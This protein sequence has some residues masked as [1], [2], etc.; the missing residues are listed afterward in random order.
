MVGV[1]L[2]TKRPLKYCAC[3]QKTTSKKRGV[4]DGERRGFEND[5]PQPPRLATKNSIGKNRGTSK[6]PLTRNPHLRTTLEAKPLVFGGLFFDGGRRTS[7]K[8]TSKV[9]RL[10]S[11]ND[12]EKTRGFRW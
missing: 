7:D 6:M 1:G 4:F 2:L 12:I 3:H 11:E 10:P 8:E 9:L 5:M